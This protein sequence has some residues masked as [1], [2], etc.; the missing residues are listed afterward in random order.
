MRKIII[1]AMAQNRA[2]GYQGRLPW[3]IPEEYAHFLNSIKGQTMVMGR[4][5]WE[6][7]G[8]DANTFANIVVTR[9]DFVAGATTLA[10]GLDEAL[11]LA[12][13]FGKDIFIAGGGQIYHE[14]V[15]NG[16]FDEIWLSTVKVDVEGDVFFPGLSSTGVH[17]VQAQDRGSYLFE[18]WI[19]K[20]S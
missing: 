9:R 10:R 14:A 7:F 15:K 18:R 4:K 12:Q 16:L 2:I 1:S 17:C 11:A 5:S 20:S 8:T 3:E 19:K 6:V 13:S